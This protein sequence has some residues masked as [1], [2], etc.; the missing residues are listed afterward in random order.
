MKRLAALLVLFGSVLVAVPASALICDA[1]FPTPVAGVDQTAALQAVIDAA[2]D[3]T[4]GD[5]T[6][7]CFPNK[8]KVYRVDGQLLIEERTHVQIVGRSNTLHRTALLGDVDP[9]AKTKWVPQLDIV[10][11]DD[12][13]AGHLQITSV[14]DCA[15]DTNFEG[16]SAVHIGGSTDVTLTAFTIF[17]PAG[18]G[19]G[20][21]WKQV[22][23][24]Q[25]PGMPS[26]R[27]AITGGSV[28]CTGRQGVGV[29]SS[30][31]DSVVSG[32][33]FDQ[34]AR[35]IL[36][37][38]MAGSSPTLLIDDFTFSGNTAIHT[39]LNF[40]AGAG[41]G[42]HR[43]VSIIGNVAESLKGKYGNSNEIVDRF[44]I[45]FD[46]NVG[47]E[48]LTHGSELLLAFK[49][50]DGVTVTDN[51][52]PITAPAQATSYSICSNVSESGNSWNPAA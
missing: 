17:G 45:V 43:D 29:T 28:T 40:V 34:I 32:V 36:D 13:V 31:Y 19:Y 33:T 3:G 2:P 15:F 23:G 35:S 16:E 26:E 12:V 51:T 1:T 38:E 4:P 44:N 39:N 37:L 18:D 10:S 20:I 22:P 41:G 48:P 5:R 49:G 46:G 14:G 30:T 50:V 6:Q 25:A 8:A 7:L 24:S 47:T 52:Q 27:I 11:S 42:V 21:T 9:T